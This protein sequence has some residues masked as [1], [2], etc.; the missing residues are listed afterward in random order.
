LVGGKRLFDFEEERKGFEVPPRYRRDEKTLHLLRL[1]DN[2]AKAIDGAKQHRDEIVKERDEKPVR[3]APVAPPS[4]DAMVADA[5]LRADIETAR[6]EKPIRIAPPRTH[7]GD[8]IDARTRPSFDSDATRYNSQASRDSRM[9]SV[10]P[11]EALGIKEGEDP[12]I[13][14]WYG[15]GESLERS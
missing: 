2:R 1:R 7:D 6:Q 4:E 5:M 11:N 13:V 14:D 15:P 9:E 10:D 12:N 3:I 8:L